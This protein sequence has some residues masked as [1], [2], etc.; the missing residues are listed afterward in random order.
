[1]AQAPRVVAE[2]GRPETPEE[3]ADRK[4]A[5]S[6]AYRSSKTTRNLIAA[7][8]ATLAVVLV[9][10]LGVPRGVPPAAEPIDVAAVAHEVEQAEGR[11]VLT[12]RS[13][14]D[15]HVNSAAVEGDTPPAWTIAYATPDG[16]L[17][18]AQGFDAD[19]AW[20]TRVLSG[21]GPQQT[22]TIKGVEWDRYV[23]SDPADA[24][25][26]SAAL[27]AQAGPDIVLVY[28]SADEK[29]L[30]RAAAAVSAQV[31]ELREAAE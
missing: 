13:P 5:A 17:R 2:L 1:M 20:P 11:P 14:A 9:V 28:G 19:T 16:F 18:I 31:L 12:P 26:V 25:N 4:A 27:A 29:T 21:A 22:V 7:L 15:W 24:G 3:A 23:V 10:V 30:E 6:E 8:L